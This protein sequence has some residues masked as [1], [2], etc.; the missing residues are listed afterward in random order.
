MTRPVGHLDALC[1][2]AADAAERLDERPRDL[3]GRIDRLLERL[4][5]DPQYFL[6]RVP[7]EP[8]NAILELTL[9]C[10]M[11]CRHC[12][13]DAGRPRPN[14]LSVEEWLV[15]CD[16]L[17]DLGARVVTLLGGEPLLSPHWP[18]LARRLADRGIRVNAVTNGWTLDRPETAEL[19]AASALGSLGLS[20]DGRPEDHDALRGRP[21]SFAR[22]ER[23][24]E[25]LQGRGYTE[26]SCVTCVTRDNLDHLPWLHGFLEGHGLK[27]WRLQVCVPGIRL[28][29]EDAVVLRPADLPRLVEFV[30]EYRER[31]A[32][33][34]GV[35]DNVG[36][37]AGCEEQLRDREGRRGFWTGCSAGLQTVGITSDGGVL[38]CLS[39][40]AEAPWLAG[41]V[42]ER[43]LPEIW[44]D[45]HAF[46][47]QRRFERSQLAG[48]CA[49]CRYGPLCRSGC[50]SSNLGYTG[51]LGDNPYCLERL[52]AKR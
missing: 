37:Y 16:D 42:R 51:V 33:R 43:R 20:I 38:G 48:A 44:R 2:A 34:V 45:P 1:E 49:D 32:I 13:S 39:F 12:G 7:L 36:Y 25:R 19:L 27:R 4:A 9:G 5:G 24:I 14:E 35:A 40:P 18:T 22:M 47:F 31:G 46:A 52:G 11:R 17:A 41:N 10:N 15:V 6:S 29:R 28:A 50:R 8:R 21:G 30:R 26:L 3:Q 23:G